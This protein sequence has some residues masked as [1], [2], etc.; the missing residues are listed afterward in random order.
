MRV[1]TTVNV[2]FL[3]GLLSII[4]GSYKGCYEGSYKLHRF[5]KGLVR[6]PTKYTI[7][8]SPQGLPVLVLGDGMDQVPFNMVSE[9]SSLNQVP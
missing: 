7:Q 3:E 1:P 5:P 4:A 6:V 8:G 9:L 2:R